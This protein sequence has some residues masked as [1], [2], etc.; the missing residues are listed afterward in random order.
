MM[1]ARR[2]A[3][4]FSFPVLVA[5]SC[6]LAANPWLICYLLTFTKAR[7]PFAENTAHA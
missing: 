7:K 6:N 2:T 5:R 1:E 4:P 3:G